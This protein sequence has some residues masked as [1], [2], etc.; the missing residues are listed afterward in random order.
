VA[1]SSRRDGIDQLMVL[2]ISKLAE[3]PRVIGQGVNPTWSPNNDAIAVVQQYAHNSSLVGYS[4]NQM[5]VPPVGLVIDGNVSGL[6]WFSGE[7]LLKGQF[8]LGGAAPS[9]WNFEIIVETPPAEGGRFSLIKLPGI[10]APRPFLSDLVNEP[11]NGLR[12]RVISDI[13]WDFLA[14]L[15]FAFVGLNDPL[16]PGYAYNDW[17]FT[18]RAFAINEAIVRAGWVEVLR[19][20]IAGETFWRLFVRTRYQ[21]GNLGEPLRQYPWNFTPRFGED[22]DAYDKGG[23]Y[24]ETIPEGYYVDFTSLAEDFGFFRQPAL[25]NWR[26][27]YAGTRYAEFAYIDGLTWEEAM[28]ELYPPA[29]ILTP[30]PFRTPTPTPTRTPWP[31]L[32]PWWVQWQ[33]PTPTATWTPFPTPTQLP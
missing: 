20:D 33:T 6:D 26:T 5:A 7:D 27:Y 12:E 31:T 23:T 15:D 18:G 25:S 14:N 29:A 11:F 24:R 21:D 22:P 9:E 3:N 16:P 19:E 8:S 30:T 1:F 13:G 10:S 28:L 32:T 4:P 17:L 2:D